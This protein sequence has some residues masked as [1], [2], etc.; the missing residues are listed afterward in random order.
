MGIEPAVLRLCPDGTIE[1]VADK[2]DERAPARGHDTDLEL[3][4]FEAR[5]G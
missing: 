5:R 1:I 4:E 2:P 3:A